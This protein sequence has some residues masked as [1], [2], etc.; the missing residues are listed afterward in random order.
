MTS[1]RDYFLLFASI[2]LSAA[3]L[4]ENAPWIEATL[5][6]LVFACVLRRGCS[7]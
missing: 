4:N 6:R 2:V 3:R 5:V 1:A 7:V